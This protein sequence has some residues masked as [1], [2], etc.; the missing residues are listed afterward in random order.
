MGST[1]NTEYLEMKIEEVDPSVMPYAEGETRS[2]V[3]I[4]MDNRTLDIPND[5]KIAGVEND[6]GVKRI[7]FRIPR[8]SQN[9]DLSEFD[10]YINFINAQGREDRYHC[11]DQQTDGEN[12]T[13]SW[14]ISNSVTNREGK[15]Q[16]LVCMEDGEGNHWNSAISELDV[17]KGLETSPGEVPQPETDAIRQMMEEVE[18][19]CEDAISEIDEKRQEIL[20]DGQT[21]NDLIGYNL[22]K[23]VPKEIYLNKS[24][25]EEVASYNPITTSNFSVHLSRA[26]KAGY[27]GVAFYV[28]ENYANVK[29]REIR[30]RIK[31]T[32]E[33]LSSFYVRL[34]NHRAS[35]G[36]ADGSIAIVDERIDTLNPN[37]EKD[38]AFKMSDYESFYS[39]EGKIQHVAVS[40]VLEG[41]PGTLS[42]DAMTYLYF[43]DDYEKYKGFDSGKIFYTRSE[44]GEKI[45][46]EQYITC[47]GDSLTALGGWT[48]KLQELSGMKVYN[49]GTGGE[50]SR[51]VMARQGGDV[52][53]V[54]N[55]RIPTDKTPVTIAVRST[56]H[57]I[58]TFFGQ[59]AAPLLQGGG[60]HVNPCRILDVE[61]TLAWTGTSYNDENG[62]WTFTR[63]EA[64]GELLID[65]PTA[66][67]TDFD[68]EKNAPYLMVIFMGQNGGYTDTD[69]LI[70]QHKKM[71]EHARAENV[72]I[73]GLSS[74]TA[75]ERK[76]Y[77]TAM[78][79]EFGRYFVSIREYL[80]SPI[81]DVQ[82]SAPEN[83]VNCFGLADAGL[84]ATQDDLE[85]IK[86]GKVPPQCLADA[87]HYTDKTKAVIGNMLY[88]K[89]VE[90]GIFIAGS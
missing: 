44:G 61:G 88:R 32:S 26:E 57:G 27:V 40:I 54:N 14:L 10:I 31:N 72:I 80:A 70:W 1:A 82:G 89:C 28:D 90:L 81:Y 53:M 50:D 41:Q 73:L 18:Q 11:T 2:Y 74:G 6:N 21:A 76:E 47:W 56:E 35:W 36:S 78:K 87:V 64:G 12:L 17:L 52:M 63:S 37:E 83:I 24:K 42:M 9:T 60:S 71:I 55:L 23:I 48:D 19:R 4:D 3:S 33:S 46:S 85:D 75:A 77:E 34:H 51:T 62:T 86:V 25:E 45:P 69:D 22:R 49:G 30:I 65:R 84:M 13:F 58:A 5:L 59:K 66:I 68:R 15:V 43:Y 7:F 39:G 8:M 20:G 16:F 38:Y 29:G 79:K 67:T